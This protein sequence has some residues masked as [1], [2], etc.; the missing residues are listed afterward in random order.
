M[1]S[2]KTMMPSKSQPD[3]TI[4]IKAPAGTKTRWVRQSQAR[5]Q[6]L[7]AWVIDRVTGQPGPPPLVS[8]DGDQ[9]IQVVYLQDHL[10]G[11]DTPEDARAAVADGRAD[12]I[13]QGMRDVGPVRIGWLASMSVEALP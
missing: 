7:S 6:K 12:A 3:D 11:I 13:I 4:V 2:L 1:A 5:G 9:I 10:D 8:L